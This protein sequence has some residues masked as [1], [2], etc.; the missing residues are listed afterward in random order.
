MVYPL[1]TFFHIVS[2][3]TSMLRFSEFFRKKEPEIDLESYRLLE[4][5]VEKLS[6]QL[7]KHV[8]DSKKDA[9]DLSLLYDKAQGAVARLRERTKAA[10]KK[11]DIEE[12]PQGEQ[13]DAMQQLRERVQRINAAR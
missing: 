13:I 8:R 9:L 10:K 11:H 7:R 1:L 12:E 6:K 3:Y 2:T 5:R 4:Q